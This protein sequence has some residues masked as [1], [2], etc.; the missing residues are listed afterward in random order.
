MAIEAKAELEAQR[1]AVEL[2]HDGEPLTWSPLRRQ[3][4]QASTETPGVDRYTFEYV[5]N[6]DLPTEAADGVLAQVRNY[7]EARGFSFDPLSGDMKMLS[8]RPGYRDW[9]LVAGLLETVRSMSRFLPV[10]FPHRLP[11]QVK[12]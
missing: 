12:R 7:L 9:I 10:R 3:W 2:R 5:L 11:Q 1:V 6:A 4:M 8:A